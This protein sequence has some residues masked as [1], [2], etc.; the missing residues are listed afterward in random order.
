[1]MSSILFVLFK[2]HTYNKHLYYI[3]KHF[4]FFIMRSSTFYNYITSV[5]FELRTNQTEFEQHMRPLLF[6]V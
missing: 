3:F 6:R 2:S 5:L 4:L 1:M